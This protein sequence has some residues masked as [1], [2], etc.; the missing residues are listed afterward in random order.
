MKLGGIVLVGCIIT[1]CVCGKRVYDRHNQ[2][3]RTVPAAPTSDLMIHPAHAVA[4]ND[5][6]LINGRAT[7]MLSTTKRAYFLGR[8]GVCSI[9]GN[10][11]SFLNGKT[12]TLKEE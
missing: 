2:P 10:K 5:V 8:D 3:S 12:K 9:S 4:T 1:A 6:E 11:V 7:G